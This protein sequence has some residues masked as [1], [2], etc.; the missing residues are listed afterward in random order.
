MKIRPMGAQLIHTDGQTNMTGLIG[1]F[2]NFRI[3]LK[4]IQ[5]EIFYFKDF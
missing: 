3:S 5:E 1:A 4:I 2:R